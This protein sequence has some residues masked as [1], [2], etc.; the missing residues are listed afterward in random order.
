MVLLATRSIVENTHPQPMHNTALKPSLSSRLHCPLVLAV[1]DT[2]NL[3][4]KGKQNHKMSQ[5][6]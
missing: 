2:R 5:L 4:Y 6:S 1:S 3:K